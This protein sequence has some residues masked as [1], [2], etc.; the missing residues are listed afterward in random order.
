MDAITLLTR[1]HQTV[2]TLFQR[3][4]A[5][6]GQDERAVARRRE[7]V[8][9]VTRELMAHATAEER[10]FYPAIRESMPDQSS[11]VKDA[12]AEHAEAKDLLGQ[13]R[14]LDPS[15]IAFQAKM[16]R[17]MEAV[18][19]H[20]KD[21]EERMFPDIKDTLGRDRLEAIGNRLEGAKRS[22]PKDPPRRS[23]ESSGVIADVASAAMTK[24]RNVI[25]S[26]TQAVTGGSASRSS[27]SRKTAARKSAGGR[28][29][30]KSRAKKTAGTAK[31]AA[32]G[33]ARKVRGAAKKAR[34]VGRKAAG[35]G[36]SVRGVARKAA[37]A[38]KKV[39]ART[40]AR[41]SKTRSTAK[42]QR[43]KAGARGKSQARGTSATRGKRS[44][45]KRAR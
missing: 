42:P 44:Q 39:A 6:S 32:A 12:L 22:A 8:E 29:A 15:T 23:G 36:R 17:L 27:R 13:L 26:A 3:Y 21:E 43:K 11:R 41:T 9:E 38:A 1:D 40:R 31:K 24:V 16:A 4:S 45:S 18:R 10:E 25:D 2:E 28:G 33:A 35:A 30:A 19:H 20:V 34:G 14:Q 5:T 37:G 7:I